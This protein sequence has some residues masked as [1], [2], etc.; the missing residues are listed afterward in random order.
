MRR[1]LCKTLVGISGV[2]ME[3]IYSW[4]HPDELQELLGYSSSTLHG[5]IYIINHITPHA[6]PAQPFSPR[7]GPLSDCPVFFPSPRGSTT[8]AVGN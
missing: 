7:H 3:C 4:Q 8:P 6:T 5:I 1:P 2:R